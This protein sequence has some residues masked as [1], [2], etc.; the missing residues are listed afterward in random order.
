MNRLPAR[1]RLGEIGSGETASR[2]SEGSRP[3]SYRGC[4]Q[5]TCVE[6]HAGNVNGSWGN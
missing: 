4:Q 3:E 1:P 6:N 5:V 2:E